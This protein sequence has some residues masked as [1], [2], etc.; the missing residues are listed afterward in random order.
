M[1]HESCW[2]CDQKQGNARRCAD[3]VVSYF[4]L[5]PSGP[6]I[7]AQAMKLRIRTQTGNGL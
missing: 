1:A 7:C 4:L 5:L 3:F 6:K 2:S